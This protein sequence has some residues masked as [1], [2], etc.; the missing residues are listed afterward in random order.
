MAS[1]YLTHTAKADLKDIGRYT[2]K[3]WSVVQRDRYL[4]M[5]DDCFQDLAAKP[6]KGRDCSDIRVG[7]RKYSAG[8]HVIF[9]RQVANDTIEVVRILHSRMDVDRRLSEYDAD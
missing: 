4:T 6:L 2:K 1:F 7:Y 8:S 9:Y 3:Q 5:L